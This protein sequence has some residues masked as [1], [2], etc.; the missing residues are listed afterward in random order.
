M[1]LAFAFAGRIE[2]VE[3]NKEVNFQYLIYIFQGEYGSCFKEKSDLQT[4]I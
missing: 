4:E 2:Q 3:F 1:G